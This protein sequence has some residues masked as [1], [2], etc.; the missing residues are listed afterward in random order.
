M[1]DA[2]GKVLNPAE[3]VV[4]IV[5]GA[6][7]AAGGFVNIGQN[8]RSVAFPDTFASG[9]LD[10]EIDDG[11]LHPVQD[12]R[13][14]RFVQPVQHLTGSVRV[15]CAN[16]QRTCHVTERAVLEPNDSGPCATEIAP[17][18]GL[19][20]DILDRMAFSPEVTEYV[21]TI[22]HEFFRSTR[23]AVLPDDLGQHGG[24]C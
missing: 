12:D 10:V 16:G 19:Q 3:A 20:R 22:S 6:A 15:A 14:A 8:A 4:P 13:Q 5:D 17:G 24:G 21:K 9:G 2:D 23:Y 1:T 11:L 7:L 18:V